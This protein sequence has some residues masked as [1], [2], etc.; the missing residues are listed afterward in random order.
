[1]DI[2]NFNKANELIDKIRKAT[3]WLDIATHLNSYSS[4]VEIEL[5]VTY[6]KSTEG[7]A[8]AIV[9]IKMDN[10]SY[11]DELI[12]YKKIVEKEY[13]AAKTKV[14]DLERQLKEL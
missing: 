7:E 11:V 13:N 10:P 2:E 1:M 12:L 6:I 4:I 14:E 3:N 9:L 5:K 8:S